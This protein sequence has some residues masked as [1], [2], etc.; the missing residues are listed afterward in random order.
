M[1][2]DYLEKS[3]RWITLKFEY[4]PFKMELV[5]KYFN[6]HIYL[7][8]SN[9]WKFPFNLDNVDKLQNNL[10]N[11]V[12]SAELKSAI[13]NEKSKLEL[14]TKDSVITHVPGFKLYPY[15]TVALDFICHNKGR[16]ILALEVG[17]GK[18]ICALAYKKI[19]NPNV[20]VIVCPNS[21]KFNWR[22]EIKRY[23]KDAPVIV[24]AQS[25]KSI[26]EAMIT[27]RDG[28]T[29]IINYE[30]V[31]K[32]IDR[33]LAI[34]LLILDEC[35]PYDCKIHT[36]K[37]IMKIGDI[38]EN[39]IPVF[40]MSCDFSKN[41]L[42]FKEI[43][44]YIKKKKINRII[45]I[46][47]QYGSFNCTENHPI[48]IKGKGYVKAKEI[49]SG[50]YLQIL[51]ETC[52]R[53]Q[54]RKGHKF[55]LQQ[56]LC[57]SFHQQS[58]ECQGKNSTSF[59]ENYKE[60]L[61]SL[62]KRV[63][64]SQSW[65][66][67][68]FKKIL[69]KKLLG[70]MENESTGTKKKTIFSPQLFYSQKVGK[71]EEKLYKKSTI[72]ERS[73]RENEKGRQSF[74][75]TRSNGKSQ[76]K[77]N[78]KNLLW[79]TWWKGFYNRTTESVMQC[80]KIIRKKYGTYCSNW[81]N[82][83]FTGSNSRSFIKKLTKSLCN[84]YSNSRTKTCN[85]SRWVSTSNKKMEMDRCK[86]SQSL[87]SSR[88]VNTKI[89][90][91]RDF[92]RSRSGSSKSEFVY[93]LEVKDN[94]NFFA[95]N[96][97]VSNCTYIKSFKSARTKA[98][99]ELSKKAIGILGLSGTPIL[100]KPIEIFGMM[101]MLDKSNFYNVIDFAERYCNGHYEWFGPKKIFRCD[102]SS[103]LEELSNKL[104]PYMIVM[105]KEDVLKDLPP[106][107]QDTLEVELENYN[108]YKEAEQKFIK[109]LVLEKEIENIKSDKQIALMIKINALQKLNSELKVPGIFQWIQNF[110]TKSEEKI[111]IFSQHL[112]AINLLYS[113]FNKEQVSI[114][115]GETPMENRESIINKFNN[116]KSKVRILFLSQVGIM[117]LNLTAASVALF[118]E[119]NWSPALEEQA[120]GRLMR[121]GQ[122]NPVMIYYA[123]STDTIDEQFS[124]ILKQKNNL[125][126]IITNNQAFFF[127][128]KS[129]I[130][131]TNV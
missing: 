105:K 28:G 46:N 90:K 101:N 24:N 108:I 45:K 89:Q 41:V 123:Y 29:I 75:K 128:S 84:R 87:I 6:P 78:W 99:K 13:A 7:K 31:N 63:Y 32:I 67:S 60:K 23:F 30:S 38:V 44:R 126:K 36:S 94:H 3:G 53:L 69:W 18:T 61:R 103:N 52:S 40:V 98:V 12:F 81:F 50:D 55:I 125:G 70:K 95:E 27:L 1:Y 71:N 25:K 37:G 35:F 74:Q 120:I 48:W 107:R 54:K 8:K 86:E 59:T 64:I 65:R 11:S 66:Q 117:G 76:N 106:M 92:N 39:K 16:A 26:T 115:T 91:S 124:A 14:L 83:K 102:G 4:S 58:R 43:D 2:A 68:Q 20:C 5:K 56:K 57:H 62:W 116:P 10:P 77:Q 131:K 96:V 85:R 122:K 33:S 79:N 127:I 42:E 15:Q 49:Q 110:L 113:L 47:H 104:K 82:K 129:L 19:T 22:Q 130:E 121:I 72:S 100:N 112:S 93:C 21:L 9:L 73:F 114:I 80:F 34:D 111:I 97:L 119:R 118:M 109:E 88:V 51:W 17:L